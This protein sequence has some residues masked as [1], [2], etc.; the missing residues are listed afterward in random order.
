[1]KVGDP[2]FN[3]NTKRVLT[4]LRTDTGNGFIGCCWY[5]RGADG[6]V[7]ECTG[8]FHWRELRTPT[9]E[10]LTAE[11]ERMRELRGEKQ[12]IAPADVGTV[13]SELL[14]LPVV[15]D[16]KVP[17]LAGAVEVGA[18]GTA[19]PT[20]PEPGETHQPKRKRQ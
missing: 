15:V 2:V 4:V 20:T 5:D 16:D 7:A 9:P 1:M 11:R 14:G 6:K 19:F 8:G 10:Q 17:S 13:P 12:T 18:P 3:V